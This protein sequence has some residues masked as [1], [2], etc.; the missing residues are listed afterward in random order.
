MN[1]SGLIWQLMYQYPTLNGIHTYSAC[2]RCGST[3]RGG[4][5]C[6]GCVATELVDQGADAAQVADLVSMLLSKARLLAEIET[7]V[8]KITNGQ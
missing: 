4:G 8:V 2:P 3:A 1:K 6:A 7:A 5:L